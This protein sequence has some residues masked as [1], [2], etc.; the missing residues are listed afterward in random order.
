MDREHKEIKQAIIY[1]RFSP[2]PNAKEC[3]SNKY[4]AQRCRN[5][6]LMQKYNVIH[7]F[8]DA[9]ISGKTLDRPQL[10]AAITALRPGWVLVVDS[11]DRLARDMLV[12]LTIY[13]WVKEKGATIEVA[14]GSPSRETPEG[15]LVANILDAIAQYDRERFARR[16]KAGLARKKA[17]G[18]WLGKP[19]IGWKYNARMKRLERCAEEKYA[20]ECILEQT[21]GG[22]TVT[23][24]VEILNH[25]YGSCRGKPWSTRTVRRI[26][27]RKKE[28]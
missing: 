12:S 24:I 15:N 11:R 28:K 27:A 4:Q 3:D 13:Q 1:C 18:E 14:D 22:A 21:R 5:F 17:N 9:A 19:P 16:T 25:K 10:T 2:R 6:C 26:I 23:R 20:I 8:A 7:E